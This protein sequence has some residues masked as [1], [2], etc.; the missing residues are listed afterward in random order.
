MPTNDIDVRENDND[1][2]ATM[3]DDHMVQM[4]NDV[5]DFFNE[6]P[7]MNNE[8]DQGTSMDELNDINQYQ[9]LIDDAMITLYTGC[10]SFTKLSTTM[11]L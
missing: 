10:T 6:N 9:K 3:I 4:V 5:D 2:D 8:N 7:Y 11:K 1:D